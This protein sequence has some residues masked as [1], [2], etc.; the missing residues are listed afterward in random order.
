M[1]W[2]DIATGQFK[3]DHDGCVISGKYASLNSDFVSTFQTTHNITE[4]DAT[5]NDLKTRGSERVQEDSEEEEE[6]MGETDTLNRPHILRGREVEKFQ[7]RRLVAGFIDAVN[8]AKAE[9]N[10]ESE[11]TVP[12]PYYW[13]DGRYDRDEL[14][15]WEKTKENVH[16]IGSGLFSGAEYVGEV[17]IRFLGLD[18]PAH[19]WIVD[20]VE[21]EKRAKRISLLREARAKEIREKLFKKKIENERRRKSELECLNTKRLEGGERE[22]EEDDD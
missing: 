22:E 10:R 11:K 16:W 2:L 19:Q 12:E 9:M 8:D 13:E 15:M 20:H 1:P 21:E 7:G 17:I 3:D 6:K 4:N 18:R 5:W 14:N